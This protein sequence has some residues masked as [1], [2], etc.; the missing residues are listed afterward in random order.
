MLKTRSIQV[1][2]SAHF[3]DAEKAPDTITVNGGQVD[4]IF[5]FGTAAGLDVTEPLNETETALLCEV[6]ASVEGRVKAKV[7]A[8]DAAAVIY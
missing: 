4:G 7:A 2:T 3:S 8:Q 5:Y 1:D 6:L